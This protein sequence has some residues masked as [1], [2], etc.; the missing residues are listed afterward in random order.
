MLNLSIVAANYQNRR[1]I[2]K[3]YQESYYSGNHASFDYNLV[4]TM[5]LS[6]PNTLNQL[7]GYNQ[8]PSNLSLKASSKSEF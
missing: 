1:D 4:D 7:S 8:L 3:G 2:F 5:P 6:A